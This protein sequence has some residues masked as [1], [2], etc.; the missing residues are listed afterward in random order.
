MESFKISTRWEKTSQLFTYE[1]Y[2]RD[3]LIEFSGEQTLKTSAAAGYFGNADMTNPEE[4]LASAV[5]SCHMLTFLALCSKMGYVVLTYED[6]AVA[7]L[8]KNE[9]NVTAVTEITLHPTTTFLGAK[10]PDLEKLTFMHD[11][12]H[13][14]C[15]V[16]N[17]VKCKVN[18]VF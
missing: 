17:S 16:A 14:N 8:D 18:I 15:F 6:D 10:V 3:H 2:N 9:Q 1:T 11:K 5:S 13:K 4:L 12:A 7:I